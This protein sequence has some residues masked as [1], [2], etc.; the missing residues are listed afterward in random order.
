MRLVTNKKKRFH[1]GGIFAQKFDFRKRN[2]EIVKDWWESRKSR[3][4]IGCRIKFCEI[5]YQ[6][7]MNNIQMLETERGDTCC[8][9]CSCRHVGK[10]DWD[11]K[12]LR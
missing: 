11:A 8:S 1:I 3:K 6:G 2:Q 12:N 9:R 5:I 7:N 4:T 10:E